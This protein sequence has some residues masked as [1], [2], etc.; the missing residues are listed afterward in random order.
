[1][2]ILATLISS[3]TF[4]A[5]PEAG[6]QGRW[7]LLV[8]A[9]AVVIV[10]SGLVWFV[11]PLFRRVI[12]ISAYEYF[13]KRFG[14]FARLYSSFAF[15]LTHFAKM[16]TVFFLLGS[17]MAMISGFPG[18]KTAAYII[19][20]SIGLIIIV[21]TLLGGIEAVIWLDVIQGFLL[22]LGGV[23]SASVLLFLMPGGMSGF[24]DFV[25]EHNT[26]NLAYEAKADQPA[27]H[28]RDLGQLTFLVMFLNGVFYGIQKYGTDQ[29][30]VQRYMTARS[31]KSAVKAALMGVLLSLPVWGLFMLIGTLLLAYYQLSGNPL[32]EGV[33]D[34]DVF[35][36]FI[37]DK[38]PIGLT[39]LIISALVAAAFSSLDSDMNCL[40]AVAVE[41]YYSRLKPGSTDRQRLF[42]G[43][44]IVVLSG[45]ASLLVASLYVAMDGA[46]VLGIVFG[47]YAIFSGGIV[48]IFLLGLLS[49]RAN[50]EG[51]YVAIAVC[52][53][54]SIY[55]VL[56]SFKFPIGPDGAKQVF[57]DLGQW[58]FPHH[59]YM[60]GV[61]THLIILV[62]GYLASF[63]FPKRDVDE[64]L[65]IWGHGKEIRAATAA[66]SGS[67]E[68]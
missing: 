16:G 5:Y 23:I 31:T 6:Y 65:M 58:N 33:K 12:G 37:M 57:L 50:K 60:L 7:I 49:R 13:E 24:F 36:V 18:D 9:I 25:G 21:I 28:W 42:F 68:S 20:W 10:L 17:A 26:I 46:G 8:Q 30:I 67:S 45:I 38:L 55:A 41:D 4:L 3:V 63:L 66:G 53:V 1:M 14:F 27:P 40:S 22:I 29:T 39:G 43:R 35:L 11:V 62:V 51:L 32:P 52:V 44:L 54:F 19:I 48:G 15:A 61:Y 64:S 34:V 56:T 47:L 2:S 59:K